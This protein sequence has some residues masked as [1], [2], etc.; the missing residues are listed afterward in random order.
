MVVEEYKM[1]I[2][3][4]TQSFFPGDRVKVKD[5]LKKELVDTFNSTRFGLGINPEF[6]DLVHIVYKSYNGKYDVLA[7]PEDGGSPE[8]Y[9]IFP[10][11]ILEK[12]PPLE[13]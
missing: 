13:K 10:P 4:E 7:Y 8:T 1:D 12:L 2:S 11:Y 9:H 5:E 3:K 6:I